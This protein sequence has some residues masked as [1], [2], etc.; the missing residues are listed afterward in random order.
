[1]IFY[2]Q[3]CFLSKLKILEWEPEGKRR[4]GRPNERWMVG[5]R[6]S[7]T[8]HGLMEGDTRDTN[9]RRNLALGEGKPL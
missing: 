9:T 2:I 6:L 8:N 3:V 4:M 7:V 1:M 5:A